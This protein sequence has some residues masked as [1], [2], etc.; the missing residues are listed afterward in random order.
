MK[1]PLNSLHLRLVGMFGVFAL[2]AVTFIAFSNDMK[3]GVFCAAI[4]LCYLIMLGVLYIISRRSVSPD[5]PGSGLSSLTIDF[6]SRLDSPVLLISDEDTVAWY[7]RAFS[8]LSASGAKYGAHCGTLLEGVL[9]LDRIKAKEGIGDASPITIEISG[10]TYSVSCYKTEL[11]KKDYYLTIWNDISELS[12]ARRQLKDRNVLVCYIV[13][14]NMSE[15]TQGIQ[16]SYRESSAK[17]GAIL[18]E[19]AASLDGIIK[20]YERD[21]YI[22]LFEERHMPELLAGK[23]EILDRINSAGSADFGVPLTVSIGLAQIDGKL[24]EKEAG[25]KIS[26]QLALQRGGAQAVVKTASGSDVYGGRTKSVQKQTKI[27]SRVIAGELVNEMRSS[28]NVLVFG[29]K[30]ADFDSV[31]A[32]VGIARLAMYNGIKVNIIVSENDQAV[33][34]AKHIL[35]PL[36]E[37]R[38]VFV[39]NVSGQE[40]L[41]PTSLVVVTDVSNADIF[42]SPEVFNNSQ[43]VVIIDHHRQAKEFEK[44]LLIS[45][46][47]PTASSSAEL[48][49]EILEYSLPPS[50]LCKE[51]A[52]LLF[53]GIL[54]DTQRFSRNTGIR[55]FG[56]AVYL[57]SEGGNP[58]SAQSLF[59]YGVSEFMKIAVLES[60]VI[61]FRGI[62][63]ISQYDVDNDE[64]NRVI[65]AQAANRMLGIENIKASFVL[66]LV[67]DA[68]HVS[69]RSDGSINVSLILERLK[70]GGHFDMAGARLTGVSMKQAL[71]MLRES[72]VEY[73]DSGNRL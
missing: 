52:E 58:G 16:D 59:K 47:E 20:E 39:D 60:S 61:I 49:S 54:L 66:A 72:I 8:L 12:L 70:G 65:A 1:S 26:L 32:C 35:S 45:Y 4:T 18:G 43:R 30:N 51:E 17:I 53:A 2:S 69:A 48:I 28:S 62:I 38:D 3:A 13:V 50:S 44:P 33:A 34:T 6:L 41:L 67:G 63:A 9:T 68:I 57:R 25:A 14:D 37:Y 7:N 27:R 15:I 31:A 23:F 29:H 55:T 11:S 36:P 19:W 24:T 73:L 42:Q 40:L 21:K 64:E 22:L 71:I 46:I 10:K 5:M 56:A